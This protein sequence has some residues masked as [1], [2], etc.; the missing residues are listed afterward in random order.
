M[1][2]PSSTTALN[3]NNLDG[4]A[5]DSKLC[6]IRLTPFLWDANM[7]HEERL[8]RGAFTPPKPLKRLHENPSAEAKF[9][10]RNGKT[11]QEGHTRTPHS[12]FQPYAGARRQITRRSCIDPA[13]TQTLTELPRVALVG[14]SRAGAEVNTQA[15][16]DID[17]DLAALS[18]RSDDVQGLHY[19]LMDLSTDEKSPVIKQNCFKLLLDTGCPVTYVH[20]DLFYLYSLD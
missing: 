12:R 6:F 13:V 18:K 20:C 10:N 3:T 2:M 19:V 17:T 15:H 9:F 4:S 11:T 5:S 1:M 8:R 7:R 16:S 14:F